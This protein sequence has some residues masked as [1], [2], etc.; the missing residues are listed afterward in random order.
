MLIIRDSFSINSETV[1]LILIEIQK[2]VI[3][4]TFQKNYSTAD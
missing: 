3:L 2:L 1:I 4:L